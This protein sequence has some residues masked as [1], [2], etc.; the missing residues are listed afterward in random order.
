MTRA[1][2]TNLHFFNFPNSMLDAFGVVP[3][4]DLSI[5]KERQTLFD[6]TSNILLTIIE[7]LEKV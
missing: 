7:T 1:Y 6:I 4:Y 2:L 5:M 3:D